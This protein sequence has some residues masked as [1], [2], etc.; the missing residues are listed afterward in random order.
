MDTAAGNIEKD[1][2]TPA[3]DHYEGGAPLT[4]E[5]IVEKIQQ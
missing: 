3:T 2:K 1:K 5:R 4:M